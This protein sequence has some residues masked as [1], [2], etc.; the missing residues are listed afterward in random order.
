MNPAN[1]LYIRIARSIGDRPAAYLLA[2][3]LPCLA[4]YQRAALPDSYAL[5][6]LPLLFL[7]PALIAARLGRGPGLLATC[8][9]AAL[10]AG[11]PA[12]ADGGAW[13]VAGIVNGLSVSLL[14]GRARRAPSPETGRSGEEWT[15]MEDK[16]RSW[17][18]AFRLAEFDVAIGDPR[19]NAFVEVNPAFA[20]R[21]GY[22]PE[23]LA[24]RPIRSIFPPDR[25][26]ETERAILM[27]DEKGHASFESEHLCKDGR[28]FPVLLDITVTKD[29]AGAPLSRLVYAQDIA[30]R[31][32]VERSLRDSEAR[33]R[34]I[35]DG[36]SEGI[37]VADMQTRAFV[38]AN[39]AICAML[40]YAREELTAMGIEDLHRLEDFPDIVEKFS[41]HM[42]GESK[43]AFEIDMVR[44][45]G[46]AFPVE[47]KASFLDIQG[48]A[49]VAGIFS[50]I[51]ERKLLDAQLDA[52]RKDLEGLV[53]WRTEEFESARIQAESANRAKSA[54]LANMSH[55]IR[56]P[57]N[58]VLGM[59]NLLRRS[60]VVAKQAEFLDK[61]EASGKHLLGV[62]N[63]ILDLSK[64]EA[65]KLRLEREDFALADLIRDIQA[66]VG[67]RIAAKGLAF[68][69]DAD[70]APPFLNGDRM[71][72]VQALV[73]YLGNAVKFTERGEIVLSVRP[74]EESEKDCLLR[75]E[76]R[77]TGIGLTQEQLT[78]IFEPFGQADDST[79]RK[80]GGTGLGLTIARR[81]AELMGGQAGAES[82]YGQGSAFWLVVRLGKAPAPKASAGLPRRMR[83]EADLR[84]AR[85]GARV[86]LAE[87]DPINREVAIGLLEA[88]G[89]ETEIAEN[90]REALEKAETG[91]FSLILMDMRMPEM[92]GLEATRKIRALPAW[93]DKPILAMTANAFEEDRL[94]CISA[95]MNG[96]V[97]KP[98]VPE[99]LYAAL[100]EW[101]PGAPAGE[102]EGIADMLAAPMPE[103]LSPSA[104][105]TPL[106]RLGAVPGVDIV[107]GLAAMRGDAERYLDLS[108]HFIEIH[109]GDPA[110]MEARLAARNFAALRDLAHKLK[111]ASGNLGLLALSSAAER[112][113]TA[114]RD[115]QAF[116]AGA[117]AWGIAD[118]DRCLTALSAALGNAPETAS[119]PEDVST[120]DPVLVRAYARE[121]A[122]LL[123]ESDTRALEALQERGPWLRA[124]LG[125]RFGTL[126]ERVRG[127][128]FDG[129][130]E[131]LTRAGMADS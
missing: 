16:L 91:S 64:I 35:F 121:F 11:F 44:K 62:I 68:R 3:A 110:L 47:V 113:D 124:A 59:T 100:L 131:V 54:F 118:V 81:I 80:H 89:I 112:L 58:G 15:A 119:Y 42:R 13:W 126:S 41:R 12:A 20:R 104:P 107:R 5:P 106:A 67:D 84:R 99:A 1:P 83:T 8:A 103:A 105:D 85:R 60:G 74:Q 117:L 122:V 19:R 82:V 50:D 128:D 17:A 75:C 38:D 108:R 9:G 55:E 78:R 73:N 30:E 6:P 93:R 92:D 69:I 77:D 98:V 10:A 88:A 53:A 26:E 23:E 56:T 70:G 120:P 52:Y 125:E 116:D 66:I 25:W 31:K 109:R 65:D 96:F 27:A 87:D 4:L 71:R 34:A 95:G 79:T 46:R 14:A 63:D 114:L 18:N 37:L 76:V 29:A 45:D 130:L 40:G 49:C 32:R 48:R 90:G 57:L 102:G 127:F 22:R 115:A 101:L 2:L 33:F 39:P 61:I 94:A 51:T 21:R 111:G 36:V 123:R 28:R 7:L 43:R 24:D 129:A 97:A 72:L 86:L